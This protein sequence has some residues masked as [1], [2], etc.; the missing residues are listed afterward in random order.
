[1][2]IRKGDRVQVLAGKDKGKQGNVI[3]ALPAEQK[4]IVEGVNIAR[5]HQ[6]PTQK[7]QQGG[8]I[9]K[10][11]PIH[12]SNVAVISP[13]DGKPTRVGYRINADGSKVRICR[14]TGVDI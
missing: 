13:S 1:M 2:K 5:K 10:T 4:V 3:A 9:D 14:R 6:K 12:V 11:M 8:I 7:N